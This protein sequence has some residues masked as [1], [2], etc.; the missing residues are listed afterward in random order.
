MPSLRLIP[1]PADLLLGSLD[2]ARELTSW[3][4]TI[5]TV[6]FRFG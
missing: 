2:M 3:R 5:T 1:G 4:A 6:D